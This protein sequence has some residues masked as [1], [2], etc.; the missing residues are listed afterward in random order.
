MATKLSE[1]A[2]Q[3]LL[4]RNVTEEE[5]VTWMNSIAE[6]SPDTR[7]RKFTLVEQLTMGDTTHSVNRHEVAWRNFQQ[8]N[9]WTGDNSTIFCNNP[10]YQD[11]DHF[12]VIRKQTYPSCYM[13][14][15]A[16]LLHYLIAINTNGADVSMVNVMRR[17]A[18][19]LAG[20]EFWSFVEDLG[21]RGG[22]SAA[23]TLSLLRE[24]D[25]EDFFE[26]PVPLALPDS[27]FLSSSA[28]NEVCEALIGRLAVEPALIT[29]Y[30]NSDI[31][32]Y[33]AMFL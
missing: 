21:G 15:P 28:H 19:E 4:S 23:Y 5:I 1:D 18:S 2:V 32:I 6:N 8:L 20:K 12:K 3:M 16:L 11:F 10:A 13:N 7:M 14:A 17:K 9:L 29:K 27:M 24:E 31:F 30:V 33:F 25:A 26:D 22:D